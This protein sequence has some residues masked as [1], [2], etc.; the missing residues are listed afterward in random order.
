MKRTTIYLP[1]QLKTKLERAAAQDGRTEADLVREGVERLLEL[2]EPH[3]RLP[4]FASGQPGLAEN[5][6]ELL[7]GFGE[8]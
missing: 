1:E 7:A 5:A 2:R 6:E 8:T 3:P 4:L